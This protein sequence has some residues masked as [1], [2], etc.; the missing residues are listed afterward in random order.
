MNWASAAKEYMD[1]HYGR[2]GDK[3]ELCQN[4]PCFFNKDLMEQRVQV[5]HGHLSM[6]HSP[7]DRVLSGRV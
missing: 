6:I 4:G 1:N 2:L 3:K 7:K 5:C